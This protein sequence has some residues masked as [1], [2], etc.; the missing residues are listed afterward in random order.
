MG[1]VQ[2]VVQDPISDI[3]LSIDEALNDPTFIFL[4]SLV[5]LDGLFTTQCSRYLGILR[6]NVSLSQGQQDTMVDT[7]RV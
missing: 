1:Y 5:Q 3:C 2:A 7:L 6:S 4:D